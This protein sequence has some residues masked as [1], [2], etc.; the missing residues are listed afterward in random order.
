MKGM[1][2]FCSSPASTAVI[3]SMQAQRSTA[4]RSRKNCGLLAPVPCSCS[5]LSP[6]NPSPSYQNHQRSSADDKQNHAIRHKSYVPLNDLYTDCNTA[7]STT[8]LLADSD[9]SSIHSDR[10]PA[11]RSPPPPHSPR[12]RNQVVIL[13]VSLHCKGCAAKVGKHISKMQG[14]TSFCIDM[15][16]KKVTIIGDVTPLG[17][18]ASVSKV[19]NAQFWSSSAS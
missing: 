12:S 9:S 8:H 19:K 7:S 13:K 2:L 1:D 18:L 4:R 3:S 14:V 17:V 5:S 16:S 11:Q 10:S 15:M 6:I